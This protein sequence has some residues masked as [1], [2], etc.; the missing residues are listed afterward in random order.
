VVSQSVAE[1]ADTDS[2]FV[3]WEGNGSQPEIK[4]VSSVNP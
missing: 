4:D 3:D 2:D 1:S